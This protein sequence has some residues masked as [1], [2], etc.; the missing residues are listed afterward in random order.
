MKS[1][2][3]ELAGQSREGSGL[4]ALSCPSEPQFPYL[5]HENGPRPP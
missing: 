1:W 5:S 2:R 4:E 3:Q